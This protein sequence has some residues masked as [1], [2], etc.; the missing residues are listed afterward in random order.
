MCIFISDWYYFCI[1]TYY[2]RNAYPC[3]KPVLKNTWCAKKHFIYLYFVFW[4]QSF[5]FTSCNF[6]L[7]R[8]L[9]VLYFIYKFIIFTVIFVMYIIILYH[10]TLKHLQLMI[11]DVYQSRK[12][13]KKA[14]ITALPVIWSYAVCYLP[15]MRL[16]IHVLI[17]AE[18]D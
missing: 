11:T 3:S 13:N 10:V 5:I 14:T 8:F 4:W 1:K 9:I 6:I 16:D 2:G 7:L 18:N 15:Y 17:I 12:S